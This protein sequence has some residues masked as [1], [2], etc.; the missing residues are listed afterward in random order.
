MIIIDHNKMRFVQSRDYSDTLIGGRYRI[1]LQEDAQSLFRL[2]QAE[3]V[4]DDEFFKDFI[5]EEDMARL[6]IDEEKPKVKYK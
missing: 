6:N 5:S 2:W 3:R 1:N 4:V